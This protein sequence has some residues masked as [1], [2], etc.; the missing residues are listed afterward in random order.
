MANYYV[1]ITRDC[2]RNQPR[3]YTRVETVKSRG[4]SNCLECRQPTV[5][6]RGPLKRPNTK[7]IIGKTIV[8]PTSK[9]VRSKSAALK[10]T[11]R[12]RF[13]KR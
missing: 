11:I 5:R 6:R 8:W 7:R 4:H 2:G 3:R 10:K 1:C 12:K 13:Y 9:P